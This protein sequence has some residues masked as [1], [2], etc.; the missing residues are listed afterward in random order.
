MSWFKVDDKI[1][2]HKKTKRAGVEA[3]G[4]WVLCGAWSS[5]NGEDGFVPD[6]VAEGFTSKAQQYAAKLVR[7]GYFEVCEKD[8]DKGWVLHDFGD[9]N[10][11]AED[12]QAKRDAWAE[13][14]RKSRSQRKVSRDGHSESHDPVTRDEDESHGGVTES[15]PVPSRPAASTDAD[16]FE[17][18]WGHYPKKVGKGQARTAFA[19]SLKKASLEDLVQGADTFTARTANSDPKF[20]AHPATWLNG[21]RWLDEVPAR[22]S[23]G[24]GPQVFIGRNGMQQERTW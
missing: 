16:E 20:I 15:R 5:D 14:Q 13:R 17:Q 7:A 11:S 4:L 1:H 3:M 12:V 23:A 10:P 22:E 24:V 18:W 9:Y 19:R 21:E 2:G 8:G 6:Y